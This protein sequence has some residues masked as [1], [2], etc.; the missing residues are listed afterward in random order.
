MKIKLTSQQQQDLLGYIE[1][2]LPADSAARIE[3]F[4]ANTDPEFASQIADMIEQRHAVA[5]LPKL[6]APADMA[7]RIMEQVER[8]SLLNDHHQELEARPWWQ[9]RWLMAACVL[10]VV[11]AFGYY[12]VAEALKN[13][14]ASEKWTPTAAPAVITER[15]L[16][17][18]KDEAKVEALAPADSPAPMAAPPEPMMR[19]LKQDHVEQIPQMQVGQNAE[20]IVDQKLAL[21]QQQANYTQ[22]KVQLRAAGEKRA[23]NAY[24][25]RRVIVVTLASR[26]ASDIERLRLLLLS[27]EPESAGQQASSAPAALNGINTDLRERSAADSNQAP[28][29]SQSAGIR[30]RLTS[31]AY[32]R[33]AS[34]FQILNIGSDLSDSDALSRQNVMN[35]SALAPSYN[36][37]AEYLFRFAAAPVTAGTAAESQPAATAPA[38]ATQP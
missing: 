2:T 23:A 15:Q 20:N 36:G 14:S 38:A 37:T 35:Q 28:G 25:G 19:K 12:V 27:T 30:A 16:A 32:R 7:Q 22:E 4:L 10:M 26:D 33:V 11:S 24:D 3:V 1:G 9:S 18:A 34:Q 17:S 13:Y 31:E 21:N 6:K 29:A 5:A 8:E